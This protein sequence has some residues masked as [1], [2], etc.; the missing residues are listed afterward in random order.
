MQYGRLSW[1]L[2][3]EY[4][5][6]Q[7][8]VYDTIV[9]GPRSKDAGTLPVTDADGRLYGPFTPMLANPRIA[10]IV[11][12]LGAAMRYEIDLTPRARE[13]A[14]LGVATGKRSSFEWYSHELLARRAGLTIEELDHVLAGRAAPTFDAYEDLVWRVVTTL[15]R[16]CDLDDSQF[17]EAQAAFGDAGIVD[18]IALVGHYELLSR[19]LRVWRTPLPE[20][21][22]DKFPHA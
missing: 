1:L 21:A 13:I 8:R 20:G 14:I 16:E 5:A 18:L 4:S 2:P 17:A 7:R 10:D 3:D 6:D 15:V 22:E 12:M 11:Q 9:A 19:S